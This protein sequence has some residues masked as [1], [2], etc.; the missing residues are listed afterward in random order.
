MPELNKIADVLYMSDGG[1]V[2]ALERARE[3]EDEAI[4]A[5]RREIGR[6]NR[7]DRL[8]E[9]AMR[10]TLSPSAAPVSPGPIRAAWRDDP[11][12]EGP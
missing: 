11:I 6:A 2:A 7:W 9:E 1:F 3:V 5:R 12:P 10:W 4:R 8:V